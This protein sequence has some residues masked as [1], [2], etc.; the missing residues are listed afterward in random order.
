M[1]L[2]ALV[3]NG[4]GSFLGAMIN[5]KLLDLLGIKRVCFINILE[6]LLGFM[7]VGWYN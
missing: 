7:I 4:V 3:F 5:G 1:A 6:N 2:L